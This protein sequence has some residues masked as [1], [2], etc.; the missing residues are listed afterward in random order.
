MIVGSNAFFK[1]MEGFN[2][3]DIDILEFV[4]NPIGFKNYRQIAFDNKC[5]FQ[6]RTMPVDEMIKI[7][8]ENNTPMEMA[9]F[10]VPEFISKMNLTIDKLKKL[11]PLVDSMDKNHE[12]LKVIYDAYVDNNAFYLSEEQLN[13]AYKVYLK[14]RNGNDN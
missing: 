7:H 4:D 2:P 1:G 8:L 13:N 3:K 12:Y 11:Q 10:L 6:W 14:Y 5:V 9:K